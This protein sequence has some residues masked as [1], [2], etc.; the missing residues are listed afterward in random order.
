VALLFEPLFLQVDLN[1]LPPLRF[2]LATPGAKTLA[3]AP[4]LF[5][6]CFGNPVHAK[7]FVLEEAFLLV[8]GKSGSLLQYAQLSCSGSIFFLHR[9]GHV[10]LQRVL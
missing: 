4:F 9:V 7:G 8:V 10:P 6:D 2:W 5:V 1:H 3:W